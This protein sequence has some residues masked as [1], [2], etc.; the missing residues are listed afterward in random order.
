MAAVWIAFLCSKIFSSGVHLWMRLVIHD[1]ES[2]L[3][4]DLDTWY[5]TKADAKVPKVT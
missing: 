3:S 2:D 5:R 1:G 4:F